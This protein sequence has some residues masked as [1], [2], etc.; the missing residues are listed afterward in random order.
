MLRAKKGKR[1]FQKVSAK[2]MDLK[3]FYLE[4]N[5]EKLIKSLEFLSLLEILRAR[6]PK[7][8]FENILFRV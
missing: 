4:Y 3:I 1:D 5:R 8:R 2:K 7:S 6:F